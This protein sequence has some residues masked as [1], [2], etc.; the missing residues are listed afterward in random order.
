MINTAYYTAEGLKE[1][2]GSLS[3]DDVILFLDFTKDGDGNNY[4]LSNASEFLTDNAPTVPVFRLA[5]ADICHGVLG[6]L[7][8]SYYDAAKIAGETAGRILGGEDADDIPLMTSTVITPCF[9]QQAMDRFGIRYNNLPAGSVVINE[10]EN[11]QKFYRENRLISNLALI[12]VLLMVVI[13]IILN[14]M[15][16][17]RKKIIRTDFLT[18]LPNR[19]KIIEDMNLLMSQSAP[20]GVIMLDVDHFKN[21]NDTYGH[22][23]GD[24]VIVEVANRL[25]KLSGK[26]ITF[27]RLGGDEFCGL[28]TSPS[29]DSGKDICREIMES[30]IWFC[31]DVSKTAGQDV[32]RQLTAVVRYNFQGPGVSCH[33]YAWGAAQGITAQAVAA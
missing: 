32:S 15:N 31:A 8:Y 27:A 17:R 10:H 11:L 5:S 24:E 6:G 13:I 23:V 19:K 21:V 9:D 3:D 4:S 18:Q 7:S 30:V 12:I 29:V 2:L 22:K 20:F 16:V 33:L 1:L 25:G 28:F 26:S 14:Y